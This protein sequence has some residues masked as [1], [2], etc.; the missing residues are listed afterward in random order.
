MPALARWALQ[1]AACIAALFA[2]S[3]SRAQDYP[4]RP[5]TIVVP[6]PP[7]AV[8]DTSARILADAMSADLGVS[9]IIDNRPG[10]SGTNGSVQV[11]KAAPD[12]YTLLI[13]PNA[14]ATMNMYMQKNFPY[15]GVTSLKPITIFG[16]TQIYLAVNPKLEIYSV[17]DLIAYAKKNPGKLAYGTA[18]V[19]SGHHI[20]GAL[21]S[22]NANID[23]IHVPYRGAAP[24]VQDLIAGQ[25]PIALGTAPAVLPHAQAGTIRI[26][27]AAEAKRSAD[28]PDVPTIAETVPG[29]VT[30]TWVGLWAPAETPRPIIDRL[31][32]AVQTALKRPD[33]LAKLKTIGVTTLDMG[34]DQAPA[35]IKDEKEFWGT[36]IPKIGIEPE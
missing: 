2:P 3:L 21:L 4:T 29:V 31:Y 33:V 7:A 19:G 13:G 25:I 11:V 14:I 35:F 28:L 17:A 30:R 12:G 27:A 5:I 1:A 20:A 9:V 24:A 18:G 26:I 15:D 34:P 8:S 23:M 6:F 32:K 36:V 22:K 10:A 16:E